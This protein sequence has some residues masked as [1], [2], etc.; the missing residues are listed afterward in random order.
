MF[1]DYIFLKHDLKA[2]LAHTPS[3][4]IHLLVLTYRYASPATVL[5]QRVSVAAGDLVLLAG[6]LRPPAQS[7]SVK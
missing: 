3:R 1:N 6:A 5:F 2:G 4:L 7:R